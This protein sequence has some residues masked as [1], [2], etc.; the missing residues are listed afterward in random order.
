MLL[1]IG[2]SM[3][4]GNLKIWQ[5]LKCDRLRFVTRSFFIG[6]I[7]QQHVDSVNSSM[8]GPDVKVGIST[9]RG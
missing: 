2:I 5:P 6:P 7:D 3:A 9:H 8:G 1:I 4:C